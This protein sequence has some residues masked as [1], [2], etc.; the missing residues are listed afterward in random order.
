MVIGRG[1]VWWASLPDPR[2]SEPGFR[3]PVLVVQ[4][5]FYNRSDLRTIVAVPLSSTLALARHSGNVLLRRRDTG[6]PK[7]SVVNVTQVMTVD[8]SFFIRKVRTLSRSALYEVEQGLR[9][10]L[11]L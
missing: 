5:D 8:K 10:V 11:S 9:M 7:D 6:L 1:E 2:G 4:S 3:R